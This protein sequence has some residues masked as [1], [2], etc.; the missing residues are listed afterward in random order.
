[1]SRVACVQEHVVPAARPPGSVIG[2]ALLHSWCCTGLLLSPATMLAL[3]TKKLQ[4]Q[5][6]DDSTATNATSATHLSNSTVNSIPCTTQSSLAV[7]G[8]NL[9]TLSVKSSELVTRLSK[10]DDHYKKLTPKASVCDTSPGTPTTAPPTKK[11]CRSLSVPADPSM[12]SLLHTQGSKL[13]RPIPVIP[14]TNNNTQQP[15][16]NLAN[17]HGDCPKAGFTHIAPVAPSPLS[18]DSGHFTTSDLQ[19]PPG[20]P[21][22]RPLSALSDVSY[23]SWLEHS[24]SRNR[25][26]ILQN[27]SLSYEDQISS[28]SRLSS[29]S[30]AMGVSSPTSLSPYRHKIPRCRSQPCV[31][32]DRRF[33]KKRRRESDRPTLNFHKMTETAYCHN[34]RSDPVDTPG[35]DQQKRTSRFREELESA[36]CLMP[37]ASSPQDTDFPVKRVVDYFSASPIRDTRHVRGDL[38]RHGPPVKS[39]CSDIDICEPVQLVGEDDESGCGCHGDAAD[40]GAELFPLTDLDIEQIESH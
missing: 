22:P 29:V 14:V 26:E 38:Y 25:F 31:L 24:P 8:K 13:W 19:T 10:G 39:L 34:R 4:N 11:Y 3:I 33:G 15:N 30:F 20:S 28:S 32:H 7:K 5:T 21:I 6:L 35:F 37:I 1:M 2:V 36:V 23:G 27:R 40:N 17:F 9:W 18:V 16:R 12:G